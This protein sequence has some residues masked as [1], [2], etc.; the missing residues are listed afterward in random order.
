MTAWAV[1][2]S[3]LLAACGS[4]LAPWWMPGPPPSPPPFQADPAHPAVLALPP[5][6]C[7][8]A[9]GVAH[10]WCQTHVVNIAATVC[11]L[12]SFQAH[13]EVWQL[14][15]SLAAPVLQQLISSF[16]AAAV[17]AQLPEER[18][19][20]W[21]DWLGVG[22]A[23]S[24][25]CSEALRSAYAAC[26]E[27]SSAELRVSLLR[28][29]AKLVQL[30]QAACEGAGWP[31]QLMISHCSLTALLGSLC[32]LLSWRVDPA[33]VQQQPEPAA[34]APASHE[35]R[36]QLAAALLPIAPSL[37]A[38]LR[39]VSPA[40]SAGGSPSPSASS[41]DGRTLVGPQDFG[42]G[43]SCWAPPVGLLGL[44]CK[45]QPRTGPPPA[46]GGSPTTATPPGYQ[47]MKEWD[48]HD[49]SR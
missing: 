22:H 14:Q 31:P 8:G 27:V 7:F 6:G 16:K 30:A 40:D 12:P 24:A 45:P 4:I 34:P 13:R 48:A 5:T 19:P 41:A 15:P 18:R 33:A 26:L 23:A 3:V 21:F 20:Q 35:E 1:R 49:C 25:V 28:A 17:A 9:A 11:R 44:L 37:A 36:R 46:Q 38:Q 32:T 42:D 29:A 2:P 43:C 47:A 39:A 10:T